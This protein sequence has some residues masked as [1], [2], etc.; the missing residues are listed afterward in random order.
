MPLDPETLML[1]AHAPAQGYTTKA[2]GVAR[3]PVIVGEF[4]SSLVDAPE[5]TFLRDF[6]LFANGLGAAA[7]PAHA[8]LTSWGWCA[9]AH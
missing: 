7:Q 5:Q 9:P 1:C 3:F 2:G 8:N 4:G 6:A